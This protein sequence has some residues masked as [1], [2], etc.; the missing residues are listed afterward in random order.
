MRLRFYDFAFVS[1][2]GT[3]ILV[4]LFGQANLATVSLYFI[5]ATIVPLAALYMLKRWR[6]QE[7][8]R[9]LTVFSLFL[10]F[11]LWL[12]AEIIWATY[13][14]V[15]KIEPHPSAADGFW[16]AGYCFMGVTFYSILKWTKYAERIK[17]RILNIAVSL[18]LG[19]FVL[20][21]VIV[22]MIANIEAVTL[23]SIIDLSYPIFDVLLFS[24]AFGAL[25][26]LIRTDLWSTWVL[27]PLGFML[28][29]IGDIGFAMLTVNNVYLGYIIEIF[30][31]IGNLSVA[32]G[33]LRVGMRSFDF[34]KFLETKTLTVS[35]GSSEEQSFTRNLGV[36]VK[37]NV[38]LMDFDPT[39][40]YEKSIQWFFTE[41]S[42]AI[43]F[44]RKSSTLYD[45][46]KKT[47]HKLVVLSEQVSMPKIVSE[48]EVWVP[49]RRLSLILHALNQALEANRDV[50]DA[51]LGIVF[52]SL[53]DI[54][55]LS[56]FE[57]TYLFLRNAL[58]MLQ[59]ENV[60]AIFLLN[61]EVH[62]KE[63]TS[64]F[65]G[66]FNNQISFKNERLHPIKML[67]NDSK[68]DATKPHVLE[69]HTVQ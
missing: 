42:P 60:T 33:C 8:T 7:R 66:I 2:I 15:L 18:G 17:L 21:T 55:L 50:D 1:L 57:K 19:T 14:F 62:P 5:G 61:T 27:I 22:P 9:Q 30:W 58:D 31:I 10:G 49:P 13:V 12:L 41:F 34:G 48:N 29:L 69:A 40:H 65:R 24:A 6:G 51:G 53:T 25:L 36:D 4:Y 38:V 68:K 44:T 35:E 52:D 32:F 23:V 39:S 56:G 47:D 3:T 46:T 54:T 20:L 45:M 67:K 37:G 26:A 64:A 43:I 11:F 59:P 28:Y 16:I 63:H